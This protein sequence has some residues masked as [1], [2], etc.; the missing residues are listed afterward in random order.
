LRTL[1]L[2]LASAALVLLV[3]TNSLAEKV[4]LIGS[5][6]AANNAS[7]ESI[8]QSQ[9]DTVT[10]GPAFNAFTGGNL[11]GYNAVMLL[12]N[13]PTDY[14]VHIMGDMPQSGQQ[15]LLNF[16]SAGGGLVTSEWLLQ[17]HMDSQAFSTLYPA[18]P[19]AP[20]VIDTANSPIAFGS[21][22]TDPVINKGLPASITFQ[23][24]NQSGDPTEAYYQPKPGASGF[25][26]TSQ[27][28]ST[29]GGYAPSY[30][31]IGWGYGQGRVFSFSTTLDNTSLSNPDFARLVSNAV[32]W[33]SQ[34][35]PDA[36]G[37]APG[38]PTPAPEPA[39][40][41]T[42]GVVVLALLSAS[43]IRRNRAD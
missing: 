33:A 38:P 5:G 10:V 14:D 35:N 13:G 4:L 25:F 40:F 20:N 12:P 41:V 30:G 17:K 3:P 43:R 32:D 29:F 2:V 22:T 27:W 9:G 37:P 19:V 42:W 15:A 7:I 18:I 16:V 28:T 23:A 21:L 31:A 8:L 36:P 26:S 1:F 24:Q 6:D 34:Q 11:S 39:T